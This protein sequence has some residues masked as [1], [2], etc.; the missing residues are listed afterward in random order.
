MLSMK[1]FQF[2]RPLPPPQPPCLATSKILPPLWHWT[3]NF[4]Q[5][6][7]F[8]MMT[9]QLKG[10]IIL[11]WLSGLSSRSA[12]VFSINSLIL[13]GQLI[14]F[15]PFGLSQHC[16]Q[17]NFKKFHPENSLTP[18]PL[19]LITSSFYLT[20]TPTHLKVDVIC[21]A[22]QIIYNFFFTVKTYKF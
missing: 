14:G 7:P 3:S 13:Y 2:W 12:F 15:F 19:R 9:N 1:I 20:A 11:G 16:P 10:K 5:T 18:H 22:P 17:S 6:C 4:K 8:Q 21:V